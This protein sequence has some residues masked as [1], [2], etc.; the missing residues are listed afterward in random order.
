MVGRVL[1]PPINPSG[2]IDR[3][4]QGLPPSNDT[5][6]S[7][8]QCSGGVYPRPQTHAVEL[9]SVGGVYPR[10]GFI[11]ARTTHPDCGVGA[12]FI[13]A[14]KEDS[15]PPVMPAQHRVCHTR[16]NFYCMKHFPVR[17]KIRLPLAVYN[18]GHAFFITIS[19]HQRHPWFRRHSQLC[20]TAVQLMRDLAVEFKMKIY[21]WCIM[22]DHLH[23]LLHGPRGN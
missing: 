4:G 1:S 15:S 9:N 12:G 3:L 6:G 14:R 10:A 22:P 16:I 20:K 13:P 11:P 21:A 17:K 5:S 18:Q 23:L 19:T 7:M 8:G 2:E